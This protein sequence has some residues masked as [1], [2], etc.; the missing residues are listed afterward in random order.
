MIELTEFCGI[1]EIGNEGIKKHFKSIEAWD[2]LFELVWNGFDAKANKIEVTLRENRMHAVEGASVFDDGEG[3][4]H[5]SLKDTFGRFYDSSKKA[6]AAQHGAHGRGRLAFYR[7]CRNAV[8]Y[9]R[10]DKGDA[11]IRVDAANIKAY[12][13][14]PL[15]PVDQHSIVQRASQGTLVELSNFT[16]NL[17]NVESLRK[18]F[19]TEFGWFLAVRPGKILTVNDCSVQIPAH[20]LIRE[21]ITVDN[22]SFEVQVIRWEDR[23]TSEKSY[24]YLMTESGELVHKALSTL[25]NKPNFFTSICIASSWA[26][27][28]SRKESLFSPGANTLSSDIWKK[29]WKQLATLTNQIYQEFL[30]KKANEVIQAYEDKGYFPSYVGLDE[31]ERNWRRD[32]TRSLVTQIYVADPQIFNNASKKQLKIIIRLLDRL[33]VSNENDALLDVLD[34]ALDLD[35]RSA[36][37]LADQLKRTSLENIVSTIETLQRRATA[38]EK[39]RYVMNEHY[40]AVLET[41]DL[42]QIIEHNTWLFGPKYTTLGAEEDTFTTI[43]KRFRDDAMA[44]GVIEDDDVDQPGD[45]AGAR[46]QTDLFLA[47]RN[48]TFD[49]NGN[50]IYRCLIIEI[51]RPAISLNKKH[52]RQLEDYADIIRGYPEFDA[53]NIYFE[54]ILVGRKIS[55]ADK[56]IKR[57]LQTL[58]AKGEPGLVSDGDPKMK[59]YV[60]NWYTLLNSFELSNSFMLEKL[61]LKRSVLDGAT[62]EELVKDLQ[63]TS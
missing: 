10:S 31:I 9:T 6:D 14:M 29:L 7:L 25:N 42:Q 55:S 61:K 62:K 37:Q 17:P 34:E 18:K 24:V 26:E 43:A 5:T 12:A 28:F 58:N 13:G 57:E 20:Q 59:L 30:R 23:P 56:H 45:L 4:D 41:P 40:T 16:S 1:A 53:E 22:E 27:K 38:V 32:H 21:Q 39:L 44:R 11:V 51:K 35:D 33:S 52:L 3:I 63:E 54:L 36:K 19:S 47:R 15:K 2:P 60:H 8:W 48:V 49:S 46:K 50:Q